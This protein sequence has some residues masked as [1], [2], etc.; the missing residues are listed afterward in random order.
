MPASIDHRDD[1]KQHNLIGNLREATK[2]QNEQCKGLR[3]SNRSGVTGVYYSDR[4]N[5][6][7][8]HITVNK[9][10]KYIGQADTIFDAAAIRRMAELK[11]FGEFACQR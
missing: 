5:K 8:I 2:A 3:A 4:W 9:K 7:R 6:Y 1:D 10:E 11:H